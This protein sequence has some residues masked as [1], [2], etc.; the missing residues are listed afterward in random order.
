M[1]ILCY[2][3]SI[4]FN[5]S[6]H[7]RRL[8]CEM[9]IHYNQILF[10]SLSSFIRFGWLPGS[11][12]RP[13]SISPRSSISVFRPS[14]WHPIFFCKLL[15]IRL[16]WSPNRCGITIWCSQH[17]I[18][19][20]IFTSL[21]VTSCP[22]SPPLAG[23]WENTFPYSRFIGYSL[24]EMLS[25]ARNILVWTPS[26]MRLSLLVRNSHKST[27]QQVPWRTVFQFIW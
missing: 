17:H 24:Q 22:K 6:N 5:K 26:S 16:P 19:R 25:I 12:W 14:T 3:D 10:F 13:L 27:G 23:W 1:W 7:M 21:V 9:R 8:L 2:V 18:A 15:Y 11:T 20:K 4:L